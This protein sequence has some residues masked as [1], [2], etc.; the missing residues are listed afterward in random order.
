MIK[1]E[2]FALQITETGPRIRL[3]GMLDRCR[4][5]S[6]DVS[7]YAVMDI[8]PIQDVVVYTTTNSRIG[9]V[10]LQTLL[11]GFEVS[12]DSIIKE[13]TES[14]SE[15][16]SDRSSDS[17]ALD[18]ADT[19]NSG[20]QQ[21]FARRVFRMPPNSA[22]EITRLPSRSVP[23]DSSGHSPVSV[24]FYNEFDL[25]TGETPQVDDFAFPFGQ[26]IELKN[27]ESRIFSNHFDADM[28]LIVEVN[29]TYQ[30]STDFQIRVLENV[31]EVKQF[32]FSDDFSGS[33]SKVQDGSA[34]ARSFMFGLPT[35]QSGDDQKRGDFRAING[36]RYPVPYDWVIASDALNTSS[37]GLLVHANPF[38]WPLDSVRVDMPRI[39][40]IDADLNE[41]FLRKS[42][43]LWWL[44]D[45]EGCSSPPSEYVKNVGRVEISWK[46]LDDCSIP[47][48]YSFGLSKRQKARQANPIIK[49]LISSKVGPQDDDFEI[50]VAMG[51][52]VPEMD[53]GVAFWEEMVETIASQSQRITSLAVKKCFNAFSDPRCFIK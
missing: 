43:F 46:V 7:G 18:T 26:I 15:M 47:T 36:I 41:L 16:F 29:Q 28:V 2:E 45:Y 21:L 31:A 4:W 34:A 9:V 8:Y 48:E 44:A 27:S 10:D 38:G 1:T 51:E 53:T 42:H 6:V 37:S 25:E 49:F 33:G 52:Y 19:S 30:L 14:Q 50:G 40:I 24:Y 11:S 32:F 20:G 12:G 22:A 23:S 39:E 5:E 3:I 35:S 13:M 17:F